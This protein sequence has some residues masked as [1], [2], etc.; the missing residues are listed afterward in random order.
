MLAVTKFKAFAE[1]NVIAIQKLKFVLGRA[2]NIVR[3]GENAG[4]QNFLLFQQCFLKLS[5]PEVLKVRIVW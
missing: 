2:G 1:A 3:K 4:Y 5:L